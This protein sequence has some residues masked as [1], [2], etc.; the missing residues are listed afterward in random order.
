MW[1]EFFKRITSQSV[2]ILVILFG[3]GYFLLKIDSDLF[4]PSSI[5]GSLAIGLGLLL[6]ISSFS[7]NQAVESYKDS[8]ETMKGIIKTMQT[9][10][11]EQ[12]DKWKEY[13]EINNKNETLSSSGGYKGV[14]ETSGETLDD[15]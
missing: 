11:K 5:A 13:G 15:F 6:S 2:L 12:I 8:I 1:S 3:A 9:T 4:S 14:N 10:H 7:V